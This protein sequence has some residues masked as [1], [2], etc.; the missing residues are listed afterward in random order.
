MKNNDSTFRAAAVQMSPVL[1]D[2]DA[3]VEKVVANIERCGTDGIRLAVFPETIVPNYPYFSMINPPIAIGQLIE[4]LHDQAVDVPGPVTEAV[5]AAAG[6]AGTVVVLGVN[7]RDGGSLYNTQLVFDD[8]GTLLGKRR[9]IMPTFQERLIWGWGDGSGLRIFET[10]VG[11]VGALICWEHY[12]PLARY[13]L[14]AKGEQIHCSHFPGAML[15]ERMSNQLDAA[16]RHHAMESGAFVVN[17]TGWLDEKQIAEISPD[18][19][20]RGLFHGGLRTAVVS[21]HGDYL[22]GPL[23]D[24]EGMAVAEIDLKS[25]VRQKNTLDTVGHYARPDILQLKLDS[26]PRD[27]MEETGAE[28]EELPEEKEESN[29]ETL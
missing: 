27:V 10:A 11:R 28:F 4:R 1:F 24:G 5:G 16:I 6:K 9:K 29:R 12:M 22:A 26:T 2:R 3:T 15:G 14:M 19:S 20:L 18:E 17:A 25:I 21:P 8:D 23:P 13:A 7:E